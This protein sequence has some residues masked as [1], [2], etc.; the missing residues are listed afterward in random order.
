[1]EHLL[2]AI[3][4]TGTTCQCVCEWCGRTHFLDMEGYHGDYD[5]GE[6]EE[7][8]EQNKKDPDK[9]VRWEYTDAISY[10]NFEGKQLVWG[11]ACNE[12]KIKPYVAH[13]WSHAKILSEFLRSKSQEEFKAAHVRMVLFDAIGKDALEA[14]KH[15]TEMEGL[16]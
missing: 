11:C 10:G 8:L 16:P 5:P 4:R 15:I 3:C 6:F 13:Y 1:M 7:L 2:D 9:Y 12:E 14:Q